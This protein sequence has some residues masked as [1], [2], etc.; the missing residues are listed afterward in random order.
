MLQAI[1]VTGLDKT[2]QNL[3]VEMQKIRFRNKKGLIRAGLFVQGE[4]QKIVPRM[5]SNL[6]AS[7]FTVWGGAARLL[8]SGFKG[9]DGSMMSSDHSRVVSEENMSLPSGDSNPRVMIGYSAH[10]AIYV[11]ETLPDKAKHRPGK[12]WKFLQEALSSNFDRI[13]GIIE[14]DGRKM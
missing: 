12:R 7:A 13:L 10:Y 11:H 14:A 6:A 2:L 9:K 4:S 3:N 1:R 8:A 5:L